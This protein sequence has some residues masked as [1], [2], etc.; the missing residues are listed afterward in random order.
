MRKQPLVLISTL[1]LL[2]YN[3][4]LA[5]NRESSTIQPTTKTANEQSKSAEPSPRQRS[6]KLSDYG[7]SIQPEPRLIVVMAAL[8]VAGFD[9]TSKGVE[10]WPFRLRIRKD[11][12]GI[13]PA[14][15]DRLSRFYETNRRNFK[16]SD[17]EFAAQYVSLAYALGPVPNFDDPAGTE[18]LPEALQNVLDFAPL[19]REFYKKSGIEPLLPT[20]LKEYQLQGEKLRQPATEMVRTVIRYLNTDPITTTVERVAVQS[21]SSDKKKKKEQRSFQERV[22]DRRFVL[23]PD[24]LAVPGVINFRVIADDYYVIVPMKGA[25]GAENG[26]ASIDLA[27]SEARRGYLQYVID[28]LVIHANKEVF[29]RKDAIK[30]LLDSLPNKGE[31]NQRRF[32]LDP[33]ITVARSIVAAADIRM[34]EHLKIETLKYLIDVQLKSTKTETERAA[35]TKEVQTVNSAIHDETIAQLAEAYENGS[36]LVFYFADQLKGLES[37]GFDISNFLKDMLSSFDVAKEKNRLAEN[38]EARKRALAYREAHKE[39]ERRR[40][41]AIEAQANRRLQLISKLD[42]VK[43]LLD[44]KN[45]KV[46]EERLNGLLQDYK[47]EPRVLFAL[48]QTSR[49]SAQDA[50]DEEAQS[51]RL[52]RALQYY[53]QVIRSKSPEDRSLVSR[54]YES[55][56]RILAFL[57][58]RE[59]AIKAYDEA[60]KLGDIDG[61]AFKEAIAA[62]ERLL[63]P[64]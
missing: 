56:G 54:S 39:K 20:Y 28:P 25:E 27:N 11:L 42:E 59:E 35:F 3:L 26:Q 17:A 55:I 61:G 37:S 43:K 40:L 63:Q 13:D 52:N 30:S 44:E 41:A 5:Q 45:Y 47:N 15:K 36:V 21:P 64:K 33:V 32:T 18:D 50:T 48:G 16:G 46:A 22:H 38:A 58:Q 12:S 14:L 6:F 29:A 31:D 62:K 53:R 34:E 23:V 2:F 49:L 1:L 8:D 19:V 4:S 51:E 57:E 9:P 60:I 7:V 10:P 24:L